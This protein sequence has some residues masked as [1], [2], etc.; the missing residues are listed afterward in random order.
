MHKPKL[1]T[2]Q[3]EDFT[4]RFDWR[5]QRALAL[6]GDGENPV[7]G[8]DDPLTAR[9]FRFLKEFQKTENVSQRQLFTMKYP[10][11]VRAYDLY[12]NPD[13][14]RLKLEA[15]CLC[16]DL[17]QEDIASYLGI[18]R[19]A[20]D[21][22][23]KFFFDVRGK[24]PNHL[25]N[26]IFPPNTLKDALGSNIADKIWKLVALRGGFG[27]LNCFIDPY[28]IDAQSRYEFLELGKNQ[29]CVDYAVA[30]LIQP[31]DN[32]E[33]LRD[34]SETILRM[35]ELDIKEREASGSNLPEAQAEILQKCLEATHVKVVD[36]DYKL[37]GPH[38]LT[39]EQ[40]LERD[41]P[42]PVPVVA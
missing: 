7:P 13:D 12:L 24:D 23:E 33:D 4:A 2:E 19:D 1:L 22:F 11:E 15:L 3:F 21:L 35:Q 30:R 38:E 10:N 36:P 37:D 28:S 8:L 32:R 18:S 31:L 40:L 41:E 25:F 5:W 29:A 26:T 6:F 9:A 20:L 27:M 42:A 17:R 34:L 39:V 14:R 16:P